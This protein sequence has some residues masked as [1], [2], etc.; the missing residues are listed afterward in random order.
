MNQN[1]VVNRKRHQNPFKPMKWTRPNGC[2]CLQAPNKMEAVRIKYQQRYE[3][4]L[5]KL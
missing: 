5:I 1:P 4:R 2:G 3:D